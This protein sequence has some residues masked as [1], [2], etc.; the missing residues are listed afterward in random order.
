MYK[1]C[2]GNQQDLPAQHKTGAKQSPYTMTKKTPPRIGTTDKG[3]EDENYKYR[4]FGGFWKLVSETEIPYLNKKK[5]KTKTKKHNIKMLIEL[6]TMS[7]TWYPSTN[8]EK[9]FPFH[10]F[11]RRIITN[12]FSGTEIT[13]KYE[14]GDNTMVWKFVFNYTA[15]SY[16]LMEFHFNK[17]K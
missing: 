11:N 4:Y 8:K 2:A 3:N 10:L 15:E 17:E 12:I 9:Y 6:D 13:A 16:S 1:R 5:Q 14:F 7:I